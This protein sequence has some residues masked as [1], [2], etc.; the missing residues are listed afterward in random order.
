MLKIAI[1]IWN[2]FNCKSQIDTVY[3]N[4]GRNKSNHMNKLI[5]TISILIISNVCIAQNNHTIYYR[6]QFL[7]KEASPD[8][9][10]YSNTTIQDSI[11][12]KTI[13]VKNI[14]KNQILERRIYKGNE[15]YGK[16]ICRNIYG[17]K[18]IDYDF[19]ITYSELKCNDTL[20]KLKIKD[21]FQNNDTNGYKSPK[22]ST[23]E[24]ISKFIGKNLVYPIDA[25]EQGISGQVFLKFTITS[26][27]LIENIAISKGAHITLDKEAVRVIK[28][29]K[30]V[31]P[32]SL[33][34]KNQSVC[35]T[36]PI[37]FMIN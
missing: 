9:A 37:M 19:D 8:K 30:F 29:L 5:I 10:K 24:S 21:Y 27:G 18:E 11:G 3:H 1:A 16:W 22:I 6:D 7:M 25:A 12:N 26:E 32:P 33:N 23:D 15:P 14:K 35:V 28:L 20:T 36:M 34:G 13:F 4:V 2:L 17:P 31:T